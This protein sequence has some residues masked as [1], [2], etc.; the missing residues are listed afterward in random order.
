MAII[1]DYNEVDILYT[2]M[3]YV[4]I[5]SSND[6][7]YTIAYTILNNLEKIPDISIN[8][9]AEMCYTSP[10]TLS[11][12]TKDIGCKSFANFKQEIAIALHNASTEVDLNAKDLL[13]ASEKPQLLVQKIYKETI[14]SLKLGM[15]SVDIQDID[16]ICK[17]IKDAK[18]VHLIGYQFNRIILNDFQMKLIKLKKFMFSFVHSGE[19]IQGLDT[20]DEDTLVIILTV[21]AR[22][23]L[24]NELIDSASLNN[25][26]IMMI[27]MNQTF[28]NN[29]LDYIYRLKGFDSDYTESA[30]MGSID[31]LTLLN[32]IYVRYAMLYGS[33][34]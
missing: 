20:I 17:K 9:L 31:F 18:K 6:M 19:E 1:R 24:L 23:Q 26:K 33:E 10:A 21:R 11:R 30:M 13:K 7:Y 16:V 5:S 25:P 8:N 15:N 22:P 34:E 12:F 3:S 14:D 28:N 27:T 2:L 32:T 29:H 4:N